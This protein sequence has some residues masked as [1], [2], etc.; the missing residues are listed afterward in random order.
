MMDRK[1]LYD[2]I[3]ALAAKDG[4]EAALFGDCA[5]RA[6]E[7]FA[8]SLAGTQFPELWFEL[9][10]SGEP[11][12]DLHALASH[13]GL[14]ADAGFDPATCGGAPEAFAWF[15]RQDQGA[16]QLALSWDVSSGDLENPAVQLL[17]SRAD[18]QLTC[19]FLT[20]AGR[21]DAVSAYRAFEGR[22]PE[23]WFACY[24]G[25]FPRRTV[26]FLRVECIP[27]PQ[28][29]RAYADD[30]ALL[31]AHLRQ[32]GFVDFGDTLLERCVAIAKMPFRI[33][34]QF[35]V[36]PEGAAGP[37]F[38]VSARFAAPPGRGDWKAFDADGAAGE[39]MRQAEEWGLVDERWRLLTGTMISKRLNAAGQTCL[40]YCFPAFLK[41]RW[42]SGDPLDAKA[43]LMAGVVT[44]S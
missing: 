43:Y 42:R 17:R 1:L 38:S 8:R 24:T 33:E 29:Q 22:L 10:L 9:P 41:L 14:D 3:Y 32:V 18:T 19:D 4:R 20:A 6:R 40:L 39:L 25:V 2:L 26:P 36:T 5:T 27:S 44:H 28:L 12:F 30:P 15:A 11:W 37:T 31:E 7:A 34:F 13:E 16:R 21:A 35:D 23:G